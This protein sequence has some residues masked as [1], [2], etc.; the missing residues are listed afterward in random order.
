MEREVLTEVQELSKKVDRVLAELEDVK[1]E[2]AEIISQIG[3]IEYKI[4]H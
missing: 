1:R 4:S 2:L 3:H